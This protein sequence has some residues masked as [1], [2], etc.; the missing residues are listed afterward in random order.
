VALVVLAGVLHLLGL[1]E[2]TYHHDEAI[3]AK[4]SHDLAYQ[5]VYS[6]DPT[7]HGP[8]LY[9]LTAAT[10]FIV[11]EALVADRNLVARLPIALAGIGM[12]WVAARLRRPLGGRA[13]WWTGLLF[14]VSP[15]LLYFGRF[16]RMDILE[17]LCA[18]AALLCWYAVLH[19]PH[20][21]WS[22]WIGL[23]VW[24][25]L[26]VATKEN[27][28]VTMA[29]LAA[30]SLMMAL[31][32]GPCRVIPAAWR[33]LT[34][35]WRQALVCLA[36]AALVSEALYTVGFRFLS[37]WSFV[38]RAVAYWWQQHLAERVPG[39]WWYYLP[40]LLQYEALILV[41]AT[42][43]VVRRGR[44][45]GN[46]ELFLYLL[47]LFSIVMYAYLGEKVPWL[48]VHQV[49]PFVPLAGLQLARSFGPRGRWWSRSLAGA[50]LAVTVASALVCSF[51]LDE[52]TP[53]SRQVESL[54]FVQTSPEL[55]SLVDEGLALLAADEPA[56][57][58][59]Y[60]DAVWPLCWYWRD[61]PVQWTEAEPDDRPQ[62][63]VCDITERYPM[64]NQLGPEYTSERIPL[65]SW[66]LMTQQPPSLTEVLRYLVK[67]EPWG[68]I[69]S[70]D[71]VIFRRDRL[72]P[73][74]DPDGGTD[75]KGDNPGLARNDE[76][77]QSRSTEE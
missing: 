64:L 69:G 72:W 5:R 35:R 76:L 24:A 57:V 51:V 32:R 25:A 28:Y 70:T 37:D 71:V 18:S 43:W 36:V 42:T 17:M 16:L 12:V 19:T 50:G 49:W 27:A 59:V 7:Y 41:A 62:L 52:I 26:A 77:T 68:H 65:R 60:G 56:E 66:W 21:A 47:G 38:F 15:V 73:D 34:K 4:L 30:V 63:L 39:P 40:R 74:L 8:L 44:R 48:L 14:T 2:R 1:G 61:F 75:A 22:A 20:P 11:P 46:L 55:Q 6:Y 45:L 10:Y 67:R 9:Y 13:A 29:L 54:H 23:A 3:H 58:V 33:W 53:A 31:I